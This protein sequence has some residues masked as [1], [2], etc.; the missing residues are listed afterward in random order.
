[1]TVFRFVFSATVHLKFFKMELSGKQVKDIAVILAINILE[2][3]EQKK[4]AKES[5]GLSLFWQKC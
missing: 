5:G 3:E 2:L 1:M 4:N